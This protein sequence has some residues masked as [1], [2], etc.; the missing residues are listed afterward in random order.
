MILERNSN[1]KPSGRGLVPAAENGRLD[2]PFNRYLGE[3][4]QDQAAFEFA[5]ASSNDIRFRE[6]LLDLSHPYK[7]NWSLATIAKKHEIS[8]PQFGEFWNSS[9]KAIA[10]ARA[11]GALPALTNDL[12]EDAKSLDITCPRCDGYGC[13]LDERAAAPADVPADADTVAEPSGD[14]KRRRKAARTER[15]AVAP[16]TPAMRT[17]PDCKGKGTIRR[18]GD[19][20]ARDK[21]LEMTG[22]VKKG[23]GAAVSITA[24]FGGMGIESAVDSMSQVS[25]AVD[26]DIIDIEP[27]SPN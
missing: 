15:V 1:G 20:H 24:N 22:M 6:F 10:I 11:Q 8:L 5:L 2:I 7:K 21:L 12:I 14:Q 26:D 27:Q 18:P 19:T 25:F 16:P 13:Q 3:I 23:G 17:C 9:Q 4:S